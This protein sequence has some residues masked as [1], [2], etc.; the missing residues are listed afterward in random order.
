MRRPLVLLLALPLLA[1][2]WPQWRGIER[3]GVSPETGLASSWPA[4]GPP[5][6]WKA[7]GLGEGYAAFSIVAGRLYTQGQRGNQEF[8]LALDVSTGKRIWETPTG[9]AF[10]ES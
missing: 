10:R 9:R 3:N 5:L 4:S 8:V 6:A 1:V 7:N 2:D